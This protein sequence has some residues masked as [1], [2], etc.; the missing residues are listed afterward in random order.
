MVVDQ[1]QRIE[2]LALAF[3]QNFHEGKHFVYKGE[4][5]KQMRND[6]DLTQDFVKTYL[7]VG[8]STYQHW[9]QGINT[10]PVGYFKLFLLMIVY[11][12]LAE[13]HKLGEELQAVD[14]D[15]ILTDEELKELCEDES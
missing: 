13:Y 7:G 6:A 15:N 3:L 14:F 2:T 11:A 9:E 4:D 12:P 8:L 10:M 1:I 5:L